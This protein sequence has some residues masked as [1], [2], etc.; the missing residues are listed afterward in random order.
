MELSKRNLFSLETLIKSCDIHASR[1]QAAYDWVH[2]LLPLQVERIPILTVQEVGAMEF[3]ISRFSKLQD[4]IGAKIFPLILQFLQQNAKN[5]S[6]LD[7]LNAL[8][9]LNVLPSASWWLK[10]RELRNH[11][12]HDYPE[13]PQL[14]A[15]NFNQAADSALELLKYWA[16]FRV[17]I[18]N[19]KEK[20]RIQGS[21]T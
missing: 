2:P 17:Y 7:N 3:M 11:L 16:T 13:N 20:W 4:T 14:M 8:E 9:K 5:D 6:F 21:P 12:V 1:L 15:D 19:L 10:I 18:E